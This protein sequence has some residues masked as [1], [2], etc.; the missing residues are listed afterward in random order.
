MT[1]PELPKDPPSPLE[2]VSRVHRDEPHGLDVLEAHVLA[3]ATEADELAKTPGWTIAWNVVSRLLAVFTSIGGF[4]AVFGNPRTE[5]RGWTDAPDVDAIPWA[6][7]SYGVAIVGVVLIVVRWIGDGRR[8][9]QGLRVAL[10]WTFVFGALGVPVAF[11]LAAEAAEDPGL[12]MLPAYL[13]MGL[14][15]IVFVLIQL[16]PPPD[17]APERPTVSIEEL[18]ERGM[19][20]LMRER[21]QALDMYWERHLD[22][23]LNLDRLQE[24]KARPLGRLHLQGDE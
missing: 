6:S 9:D 24:L 17:P 23:D 10:V 3:Y 12:T 22:P 16:S 11:T 7:L 15:V 2:W 14:A 18:D 19:K 13:M 4:A 5:W 1:L 20:Y 21:D 8:R